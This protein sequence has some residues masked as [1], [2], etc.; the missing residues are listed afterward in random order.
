MEEKIYFE[1]ST[2]DQT[3]ISAN[4][5]WEDVAIVTKVGQALGGNPFGGIPQKPHE[6]L[7]PTEIVKKTLTDK[8]YKRF[9]NL[10]CRVNGITVHSLKERKPDCELTLIE[11]QRTVEEV[12]RPQ[13]KVTQIGKQDI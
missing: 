2:L 11:I 1:W 5:T 4:Y 9:V 6:Y 13:V 12:L 10:V 3:W 7:R 8:E